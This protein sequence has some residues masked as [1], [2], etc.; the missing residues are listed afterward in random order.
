MAD[1]KITGLTVLGAA[2]ATGDLV[3][4]VDVSDT[5]MSANGTNKS[6][7]VA[8]LFNAPT[9][10][11]PTITTSIV[12]TSNDGAALGSTANQF[13]DLFLAEGGVINFD[14]G[15]VTLTQTGNTLTLGGGTLVL[16]APTATEAPLKIGTGGTL[17]TTAED[18][19]IEMD[20]NCFYGTV[21]AGNRGVM[22]IYHITRQDAS[23]SLSNSAAEQAIFGTSTLTLETGTYRFNALIY[24]TGMSATSG[25]YA[26]D[27]LGAGTATCG[28]WLF[29]A[30]GI[31]NTTPTN[32]GTQT[33][34]FT[35]TQQSVASTHTA[36]TGTAAGTRVTGTFE[37][38]GGGTIIPSLT[39]VTASAATLA[40]GSFFECWRIGSTSLT[41]VGQWA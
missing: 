3:E 25:N 26:L 40:A 27:F 12:P 30:V 29:H 39:L 1:T 21:D 11:A 7:T 18:G 36:G 35:I 22:P 14:N 20:D 4:L 8:N 9:I 24:V 15:D 17:L 34:A 41:T 37:V 31:D 13:S 32:A 16:P 23:R 5:T 28:T 19:A 6:M 38:T 2:P 33:G 10:T